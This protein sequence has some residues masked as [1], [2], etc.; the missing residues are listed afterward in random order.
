LAGEGDK[1]DRSSEPSPSDPERI[2]EQNPYVLLR[3]AEAISVDVGRSIARIDPEVAEKLK[4]SEGDAIEI[5]GKRH[6]FALCWQ[7]NPRDTGKGLIRIDGYTRENAEV[8]IDD[9][10]KVRKIFA[11]Y[12]QEVKLAPQEQLRIVGGEEYVRNVLS[13]RIIAKGESIPVRIMGRIV[14]LT[15]IEHKPETEAVIVCED[16]SFMIEERPVSAI[17]PML[18]KGRKELAQG[19]IASLFRN[20]PIL[21]E[22]IEIALKHPEILRSFD[23]KPPSFLLSFSPAFGFGD[24]QLKA[25]VREMVRAIASDLGVKC[26][27]YQRP[28]VVNQI[29]DMKA[30]ISSIFDEARR[31]APSIILIEDLDEI[32][33]VH[34]GK[35]SDISILLQSLMDGLS[36]CKVVILATAW[37]VNKIAESEGKFWIPFVFSFAE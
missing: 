37:N 30:R 16:T 36:S 4:I 26:F 31:K 34:E 29:D 28:E 14:K 25:A 32:A 2:P 17:A 24:G 5:V 12:A 15:V 22:R 7:A 9:K 27:I 8:S 10:V 33:P 19:L 13:G 1:E 21:R 23:I 6:T 20:L 18:L 35:P 3:V 11:K